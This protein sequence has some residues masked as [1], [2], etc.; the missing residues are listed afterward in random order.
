MEILT[1]SQ[2]LMPLTLPQAL[3]SSKG[4]STSTPSLI[5]VYRDVLSEHFNPGV[6]KA[7]FQFSYIVYLGWQDGF[8]LR[9]FIILSYLTL[10][11][12]GFRKAVFQ[13]SHIVYVV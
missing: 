10:V 5:P 3:F 4:R 11:Y 13:L 7:A 12:P 8:R 1:H 6:C 2:P 9:N